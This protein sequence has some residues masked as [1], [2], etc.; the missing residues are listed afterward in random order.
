MK[1]QTCSIFAVPENP[2]LE[3]AFH[4]DGDVVGRLTLEAG[5]IV[6]VCKPEE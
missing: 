6:V 3:L 1:V 2:G 4:V 5:E